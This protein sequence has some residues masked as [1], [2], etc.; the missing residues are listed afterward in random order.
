MIYT[1][2]W[3]EIYL[4]K[5]SAEIQRKFEIPETLETPLARPCIVLYM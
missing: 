4:F 5:N 2:S 1:E 3:S